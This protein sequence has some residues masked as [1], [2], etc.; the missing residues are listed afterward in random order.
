MRKISPYVYP[1]I[2]K[3]ERDLW[4]ELKVYHNKESILKAVTTVHEI[5]I[6]DI[7]S[8]SKK[9]SR[10][11]ARMMCSFLYNKILE[12]PHEE[13][14]KIFNKERSTITQSINT[15]IKRVCENNML[16]IKYNKVREYLE[17]LVE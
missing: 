15:F 6:E 14:S 12:M 16:Y 11:E 9:G 17:N 1:G 7:L 10:A 13:I 8:K 5:T 4:L 2:K 3:V